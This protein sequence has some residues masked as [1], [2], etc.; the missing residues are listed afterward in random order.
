MNN[1]LPFNEKW[2][3][4]KIST[5]VFSPDVMDEELKWHIDMEDRIVEV[6][7]DNDW[8]FQFDDKLPI[9]MKGVIEI[10]KGEWHRIIKGSTPLNVKIT[11]I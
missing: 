11:R 4:E 3:S 9:E 5:R 6:L 2:I 8:K 7:N 1:D 10:K